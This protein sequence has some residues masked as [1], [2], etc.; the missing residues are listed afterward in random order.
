MFPLICYT[1]THEI[2][3]I[4]MKFTWIYAIDMLNPVYVPIAHTEYFTMVA[5]SSAMVWNILEY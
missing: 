4:W 1:N 2:S 5:Q 3:S